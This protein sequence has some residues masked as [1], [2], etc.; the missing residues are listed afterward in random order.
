MRSAI[1]QFTTIVKLSKSFALTTD[2]ISLKQ[3]KTESIFTSSG[4]AIDLIENETMP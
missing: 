2:K 1:F 3:N 4:N